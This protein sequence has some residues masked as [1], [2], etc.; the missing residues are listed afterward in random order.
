MFVAF[1]NRIKNFFIKPKETFSLP[2]PSLSLQQITNL[3]QLEVGN[4]VEIKLRNSCVYF[5][6]EN[7]LFTRFS[8]EELE[9]KGVVGIVSSVNSRPDMYL[10]EDVVEVV[11][12][13]RN[14]FVKTIPILETEIRAVTRLIFSENEPVD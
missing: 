11:L 7:N 3:Q 13:T 5:W 2:A 1:L 9:R 6:L 8:R 12:P 10:E 4:I 14:G